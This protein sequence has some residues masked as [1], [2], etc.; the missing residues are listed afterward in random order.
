MKESAR[1]RST[2]VPLEESEE[3]YHVGREDEQGVGPMLSD[4]NLRGE[5]DVRCVMNK[6]ATATKNEKED[7]KDNKKRDKFGALPGKAGGWYRKSAGAKIGGRMTSLSPWCT[8][9]PGR[10]SEG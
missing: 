10:G 5:L 8:R 3:G 2:S 4:G 9:R 7:Q 6:I 1:A